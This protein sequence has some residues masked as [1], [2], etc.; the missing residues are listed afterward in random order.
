MTVCILGMTVQLITHEGQDDY[1][2]TYS[3]YKTS[4]CS[5]STWALEQKLE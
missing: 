5:S 1:D 3:A 4:A 2:T